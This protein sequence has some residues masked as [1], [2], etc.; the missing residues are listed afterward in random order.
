MPDSLDTLGKRIITSGYKGFPLS[1]EGESIE[2]F[3]ASKPNIFTTGFQFPLAILRATALKN[4]LER[5]A[6]FCT[7]ANA[8]LAPHVKTTMSPQIA[9][10]Q[11][12]HGAWALTVANFSQ[13]RVFLNYG[14]KRLI[15][16]NEIVDA[17]SIRA[18]ANE[19][20]KPGYE[21]IFYL[22]SY[23]GLEIIQAALKEMN[24][25]R[26]NLFLEIGLMGGRGG[27]R[28]NNEIEA[29]AQKVALDP[30]LV[31]LGVSGFE[32]SVPGADRTADGVAKIRAYCR[33]IVAAARIVRPFVVTKEIIIS[34][35]GSAYFDIIAEEFHKFGND[36]HVVLRSGGYITHDHGYYARIYPFAQ[37]P[38][39]KGF[40]PA[41]ELWARVLTQP[42]RG[43]A[44]LNFGKRDVG[45]DL[46]EPLP[47]KRFN[48]KFVKMSGVIDHLNDQHGY[49]TFG[50]DQEIVVGDAIGLGISHPCTT[51]DK[52]H[53][54]PV[55]NDDY[56]VVDCIHTFF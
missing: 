51:L 25:V 19:N 38:A 1:A 36:V 7:G 29:L 30:R 56:E 9:K 20:S 24:N 15:I 6:E 5:M 44:I 55:V 47:I 32:G 28:D 31:L 53:L 13:A 46:D 50:D 52:W 34:G 49:L 43:L 16:A 26:I 35:G 54:I 8:S 4:N 2:E 45:N 18:I 27:I 39:G 33:K 10:R 17:D 22:D 3:L 41:I 12:E 42:E 11:M 48:G 23:A 21:I 37:E 40:M 14:F